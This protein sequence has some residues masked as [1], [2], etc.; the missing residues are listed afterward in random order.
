MAL[1]DFFKAL[2][3]WKIEATTTNDSDIWCFSPHDLISPIYDRLCWYFGFKSILIPTHK[4]TCTANRT[5]KKTTTKKL[6]NY[7]Q[8]YI[9][10]FSTIYSLLC[11][12]FFYFIS[13]HCIIQFDLFTFDFITTILDFF[14]LYN[15]L[16]FVSRL[17]PNVYTIF[18]FIYNFE[19][20]F[21]FWFEK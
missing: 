21:S 4:H 14:F 7:T 3:H 1:M 18:V 5:G 10:L 12:F 2:F 17:S 19:Y 15:Y 8:S 16:D 20:V 9:A 6:T 13:V 11:F